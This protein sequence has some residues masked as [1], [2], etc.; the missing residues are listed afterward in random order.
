M[1]RSVLLAT[2]LTSLLS[3]EAASQAAVLHLGAGRSGYEALQTFST[4]M[5]AALS[6]APDGSGW[7]SIS[8]G[9]PLSATEEP[10]WLAGALERTP[11]LDFGAVTVGLDL[12]AE[13]YGYRDPLSGATGFGGTVAALP[14][15]RLGGPVLGVR[16]R[17]GVR[18][19]GARS[20]A[21]AESRTVHQ[22]DLKLEGRVRGMG[23]A[24]VDAR[25]VRSP[26]GATPFLGGYA[27]LRHARGELRAEAGQWLG[28]EV[29]GT[30]WSLQGVMGL[31]DATTLTAGAARQATDPLYLY[32][33]RTS[34]SVGLSV[35]LGRASRIRGVVPVVP[36]GGR[37]RIALPA[38]GVTGPLHVAGE[39]S[40]WEP[41]PMERV[42][43]EWVLE[44]SL[45]TG[46][47]R[48]AVRDG[49]GRWFVPD[50]AYSREDGMGGE[51]AILIVSD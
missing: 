33:A 48:Y 23:L 29:T 6:F 2:L 17:S 16:V 36:P 34:W 30:S 45:D 32:E 1:R 25:W 27:A 46:S 5:V 15:V 13:A 44:L 19:T 14:A 49:T 9:I 41:L 21:Y 7:T 22:T 50:A 39:F 28:E 18:A 20:L 42:G 38:A 35:A 47:Y 40:R 31:T 24:G 51:V 4:S 26:E 11:A 12:A 3:Q 10:A 8:V 43:D 37:V